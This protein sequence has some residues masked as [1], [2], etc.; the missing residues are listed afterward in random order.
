MWIASFN[1][2]QNTTTTYQSPQMRICIAW[3]LQQMLEVFF[4]YQQIP[5]ALEVRH[6]CELLVDDDLAPNELSATVDDTTIHWS[7]RKIVVDN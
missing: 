2:D 4:R 3:L 7:I 6:M 5:M 1:I